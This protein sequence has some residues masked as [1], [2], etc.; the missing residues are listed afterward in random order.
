MRTYWLKDLKGRYSLGDSGVLV[1]QEDVSYEK[2]V[3]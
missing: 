1:R 2:S 3:E